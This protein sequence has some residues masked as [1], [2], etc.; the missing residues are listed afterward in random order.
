M[1][2]LTKLTWTHT[3]EASIPGGAPGET[4][5]VKLGWASFRWRWHAEPG[6]WAAEGWA[7]DRDMEAAKPGDQRRDMSWARPD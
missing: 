3:R 2:A 7:P 4:L 6:V 1:G 5:W